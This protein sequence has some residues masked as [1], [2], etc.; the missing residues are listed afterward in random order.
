MLK[1][2]LFPAALITAFLT[3]RGEDAQPR[4]FEVSLRGGIYLNNEQPWLLEPSLSWH[5]HKYLGAALGVEISSQYN[6]PARPAVIE[7]HEAELSSVERNIGWIIFK[8]RIILKSPDIWKNADGDLRLWLQAEPGVS[9]ACPFRNSLTYEIKEIN[10]AVGQTVGYRKFPNKGLDW[11]CWNVGVSVN[12]SVD[13]F[14]IGA[15]YTLS[16]LDYYS[17]RRDVTLP[18][19][20]KFYV[21]GKELSQSI[22][23]SFGYRF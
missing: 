10:G 16:N 8:P 11:F 22:F 14:V 18:S 9:L 3:A 6:Q 5:F 20:N 7:G 12:M 23:L 4:P 21:P 15:G 17:C 2:I 19:G 13:R 1:K